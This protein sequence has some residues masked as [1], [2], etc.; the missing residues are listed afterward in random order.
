MKCRQGL[1]PTSTCKVL[2]NGAAI[3]WPPVKN[4]AGLLRKQPKYCRFALIAFARLMLQPWQSFKKFMLK[5]AKS[6]A[7]P[8]RLHPVQR[9]FNVGSAKTN[10]ESL[11]VAGAIVAWLPLRAAGQQR[12]TSSIPS[13]QPKSKTG[14]KATE[15]EWRKVKRNRKS[16]VSRIEYVI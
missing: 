6:L 5:F 16:R 10:A 2:A 9:A 8:L 15:Q 7:F 14:P 11:P 4:V 3:L 1:G 13:Q 12:Q